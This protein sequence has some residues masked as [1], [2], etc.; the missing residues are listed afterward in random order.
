MVSGG[1]SVSRREAQMLRK[2]N[3]AA[4]GHDAHGHGVNR[5]ERSRT[6]LSGG[7]WRHWGGDT[8]CHFPTR[9]P[10]RALLGPAHPRMQK[11]VS[12]EKEVGRE[13]VGP[14]REPFS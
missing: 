6:Q 8:Y 7:P 10:I 4:G 13:A 9:A 12:V 3:R 2:M 5:Q 14:G 1:S 11:E